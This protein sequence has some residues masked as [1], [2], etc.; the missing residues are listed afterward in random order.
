M[1]VIYIDEPNMVGF[2]FDTLTN[3]TLNLLDGEFGRTMKPA[4]FSNGIP[5]QNTT[6]YVGTHASQNYNHSANTTMHAAVAMWLF[7]QTVR[8]LVTQLAKFPCANLLYS[9]LKSISINLLQKCI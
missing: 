9:G 5:E 1:N 4:D 3:V 7:A 6:F 8:I 2:S